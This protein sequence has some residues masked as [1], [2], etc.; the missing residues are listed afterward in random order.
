LIIYR[1]QFTQKRTLPFCK[2]RSTPFLALKSA[3]LAVS[4]NA[5]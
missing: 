3:V 1:K 2:N 5:S 4:Q